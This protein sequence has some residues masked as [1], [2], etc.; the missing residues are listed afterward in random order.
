MMAGVAAF[1]LVGSLGAVGQ[2]DSAETPP[3]ASGDQPAS[4]S[5][6]FL[7]PATNPASSSFLESHPDLL[8]AAPPESTF[9]LHATAPA[10]EPT[11]ESLSGAASAQEIEHL[12]FPD[13]N[14]EELPKHLL[15][16]YNSRDPDSKSLAVYYASRRN[17][18]PER[19]LGIACSTQEEITRGEYENT[20]REPIIS[21]IYDKNWMTRRSLPVRV[22][23]RTMDLLVA[24]R[25]NVWAMVLMRGVPLRIANDP[26]VE[27][28]L[29]DTPA[30][31]TNAAAVD[32]ELALLPIFGLPLGGCVPNVFYDRTGSG[33]IRC[34][35]ELATK[36]ILVTRL[37]GPRAADVRRMIDDSLY[38]EQNRLAGLAVIDTRGLTDEKNHYTEGDDWLRRSQQFLAQDGWTIE[39]DDRPDVLPASEPC[40]HVAFYL[41]W[42]HEGAVG[43]WVTPPNRFV[44]GAVAYHLHSFSAT[45]V[46]SATQGWVGPLIAHG[47]AATMG[48]VYE[49]YLDLTPHLNIFTSHL[50]AGEYFAEAAYA[51]QR[52]LS[53]M[54]TVVGDPLYRP[55]GKSV[56]SALAG[57]DGSASS[58]HYDWLLLQ[59]TRKAMNAGEIP[60]NVESLEHYLDVP[61]AVAQEGLGDLLA[62]L[63]DPAASNLA[64]RAYREAATLAE[65]P[66]DNIRIG[67]KLAQLERN[68]GDGNKADAELAAL[69]EL[70]P[71]EAARFGVEGTLAT[72][73]IDSPNLTLRGSSAPADLTSPPKPPGPPKPPSP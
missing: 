63:N 65:Q 22:G 17:I 2:S 64:E 67:L 58:D 53:W 19:V 46:R 73:N 14:P 54:V 23:G 16:V 13:G 9:S 41:G 1:L 4:S 31:E 52:A 45:T 21:Y 66:V 47:A 71:V 59:Q 32:S 55:F 24:T 30:L 61:G 8:P 6:G 29:E 56:D 51:S 18:P 25:N 43:P 10:E 35:P 60:D 36:M 7:P 57:M 5:P 49:P 26:S 68:H 37:D 12:S 38:A 3:D 69:R 42:Y 34:G 15:V 11:G 48:C 33:L 39:A 27:G 72:T 44:R 70:Y 40:N 62:K 20:I 28:S 50:L